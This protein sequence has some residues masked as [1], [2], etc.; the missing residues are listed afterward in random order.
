[1]IT[2]RERLAAEFRASPDPEA[3]LRAHSDLPGPR[4]NLELLD[5]ASRAGERTDLIRWA[6]LGPDVAPENTPE[7]FLACVGIVGLGRMVGSGDRSLVP[8]LR[9]ASADPRWRVGHDDGRTHI[10]V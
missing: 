3:Y 4:S 2:P 7:V 1:M 10:R 9:R 8:K 6:A 5:V